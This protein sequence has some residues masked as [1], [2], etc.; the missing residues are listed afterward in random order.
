ML[1]LS[2]TRWDEMRNPTCDL[3]NF[4]NSVL[5]FSFAALRETDLSS[6]YFL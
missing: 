1:E 3:I 4:F 5:M 6:Y 2:K